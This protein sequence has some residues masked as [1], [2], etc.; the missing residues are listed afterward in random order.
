M[1]YHI[2]FIKIMGCICYSKTQGVITSYEITE[3]GINI[4]FNNETNDIILKNNNA[5]YGEIYERLIGLK[6]K[7]VE[8]TYYED[9][10]WYGY[11][12]I[13]VDLEQYVC[14]PYVDVVKG[15]N[16]YDYQHYELILENP[17]NNYKFLVDS[18]FY[19]SNSD[20][21]KLGFGYSITY[22]VFSETCYRITGI[23][24]FFDESE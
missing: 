14:E 24:K 20:I 6:G 22:E 4:F 15:I 21:L 3:T 18:D 16:M 1:I 12:K 10:Y 2:N 7:S 5:K 19:K 9:K 11:A 8:I 17:K 13:V 23:E